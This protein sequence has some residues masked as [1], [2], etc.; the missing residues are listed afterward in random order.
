MA[1]GPGLQ[2]P[3]PRLLQQ[4]LRGTVIT[5]AR[6]E[7]RRSHPAVLH[8]GVPGGQVRMFEIGPDDR[9]DLALRIEALE[10]M[11][12]SSLDRGVC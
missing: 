3:L 7:R 5:H 2:E 9:L 11:A 4:V 10:A 1:I 12:R 8:V 6:G